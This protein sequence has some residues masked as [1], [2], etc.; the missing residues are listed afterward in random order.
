LRKLKPSPSCIP[1]LQRKLRK[2]K[3]SPSHRIAWRATGLFVA[4]HAAAVVGVAYFGLSTSGA[5]LAAVT[6][7]I[8]MFA[9]SAGTHR[10]F[11]HH[12]FRTSRAF[13]F[14]LA[15]V[16][17]S[18]AQLGVLWWSS[19]HRLHHRHSDDDADP[20]SPR[21]GL[22][23]AHAGWVLVHTHDET[24]WPQVQDFATF[25]ELRWL[26]RHY[27]VPVAALIGGLLAVGGW[28]AVVWGF[29]VSTVVLWHAWLSLNS[30]GHRHGSQR[31][32]TSDDSRNNIA[33]AIATFGEGWHNNHHHYPGSARTGFYWWEVDL[34]YYALRGLAA[35]GV[36]W[37][38]RVVPAAVRDRHAGNPVLPLV[39]DADK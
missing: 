25:P 24:E 7:G 26:D 31:Y 6:Y 5:L 27:F 30:I 14:V 20:H 18:S 39:A 15:V 32:R 21:R 3:P 22:W 19:Q 9:V 17:T 28:P 33:V 16:A 37:D 35:I 13:Q 12:A 11:A 1:E 34:T 4:V 8:R 36:V 29:C 23:W 38:L 2:L 10:H